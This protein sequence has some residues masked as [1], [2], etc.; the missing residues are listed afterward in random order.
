MGSFRV[1]RGGSWSFVAADCRSAVR[2]KVDPTGRTSGFGFRL[3][4]SPSEVSRAAE[5]QSG[6]EIT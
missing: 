3:A 1:I 2:I 6:I 5:L 4:L